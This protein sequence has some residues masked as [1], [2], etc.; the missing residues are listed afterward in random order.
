[1]MASL[2]HQEAALIPVLV[3]W[4]KGSDL[5]Q[6]QHRSD[7]KPSICLRVAKKEK[8]EKKEIYFGSK[9]IEGVWSNSESATA[10]GA[11]I[12]GGSFQSQDAD[13]WTD[14]KLG[15]AAQWGLGSVRAGLLKTFLHGDPRISL[16]SAKDTFAHCSL[17]YSSLKVG[18][19]FGLES[20]PSPRILLS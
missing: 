5:L 17:L 20:F 11:E 15:G 8:R 12:P 7:S 9:I 14:A 6:L 18:E 2:Q 1:M 3:L 16:G 13:F 10:P 4:V 19:W